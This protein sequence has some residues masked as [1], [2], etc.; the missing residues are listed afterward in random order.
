MERLTSALKALAHP[1]RLRLLALIS[2]GELTVSELTQITGLSQPR[3]TQYIKTLETAGVLE[4]LR[5]GSWVFSRLRRGNEGVSAVVAASLA[6]LPPDDPL[7]AADWRRL[8]DVRAQRAEAAQAFFADVANDRGQLG[9]EYLP[10]SDIDKAMRAL[11][12]EGPFKRHVD[13]GTGT[14]RVLTLFA[15]RVE[16]GSGI[17]TS[18][19]ML[20]VARHRLAEADASHLSVRQGDLHATPLDA[21]SADLVTLHQVLHYLEDPSEAIAEA[22]RLL[23]PGGR[24]L[25]VDYVEHQ[26]EEFRSDYRHRRLGFADAE[27]E[28]SL[29]ASGLALET[30][31]TVSAKARPD[32]RLWLGH[33]PD[34]RR[35]TA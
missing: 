8:N 4:R 1:E 34:T 11:V 16:R 23:S 35:K 22:A 7:L 3:V 10:Q 24:V 33:K 17:D 25:I 29:Q 26:R 6:A 9:E 15:D 30:T 20:R 18:H 5:E 28:E 19:E 31:D 21:G 27:I 14:A 12:G 2:D 13:L 32:V